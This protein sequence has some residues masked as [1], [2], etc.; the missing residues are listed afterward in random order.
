M[1]DIAESVINQLR[2]DDAPS[3]FQLRVIGIDYAH[4]QYTF[5]NKQFCLVMKVTA[6]VEAGRRVFKI[7]YLD[8][9]RLTHTNPSQYSKGWETITFSKGDWEG[10]AAFA[11]GFMGEGKRASQI[12]LSR[13][14]ADESLAVWRTDD[15]SCLGR[16]TLFRGVFKA[17]LASSSK[18]AKV[19]ETCQNRARAG[20][21]GTFV[22]V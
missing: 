10:A 8:N 2:L 20:E 7:D 22:E 16:I 11:D 14:E 13:L 1:Q 4:P 12:T 6:P 5:H 18:D 17:L 3:L 9:Y 21:R 15:T 19:D